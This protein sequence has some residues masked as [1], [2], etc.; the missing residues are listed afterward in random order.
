MKLKHHLI[1]STEEKDRRLINTKTQKEQKKKGKREVDTAI[2]G[3]QRDQFEKAK[4]GK[5]V[6][7]FLFIIAVTVASRLDKSFFFFVQ[8]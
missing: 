7:F 2:A 4:C 8:K 3:W 5:S 6:F 1:L